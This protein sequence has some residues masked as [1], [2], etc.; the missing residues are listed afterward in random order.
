MPTSRFPAALL[1]RVLPFLAFIGALAA[2]SAFT[3]PASPM[4]WLYAMQP[5]A[6]LVLL[7]ALWRHLRELAVLPDLR[8][9]LLACLVGLGVFL[10]WIAP[11]PAWG[12]IGA[13]RAP[14]F[15]P[16]LPDGT[17]IDHAL[18]ALRLLSASLVVPIVEE[19]FW[20]SFLLR[21]IDQRHFLERDP[22]TVTP[23]AMVLSSVVFALEHELWIAGAI[24]GAAYS[25]VYR[26]SGKLLPAVISHAITNFA[27]GAWVIA[28]GSWEYW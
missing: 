22:T 20:R 25:W 17:H 19:L 2:R 15:I 8:D 1:A 4:P 18:V 21:W 12:R 23:T 14:A 28:S 7:V 10:V 24:A 11:W 3:S 6:A 9:C 26:R 16:V 13:S 27:L 5:L